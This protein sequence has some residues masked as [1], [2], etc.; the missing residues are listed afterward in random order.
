LEDFMTDNDQSTTTEEPRP[1]FDLSLT[2]EGIAVNR[3][4]SEAMASDIIAI[5]MGG[6]PALGRGVGT[7]PPRR[8][9]SGQTSI[10][11]YLDEAEATKI[12]QIITVIGQFLMDRGQ[13][14]F[15]RQDVKSMFPKAGEPTPSNFARDFALAAASIWIAEDQK[16]EFY[17]TDRGRGAIEAKFADQKIRRRSR[18][19]PK[20][21]AAK[22]AKES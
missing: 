9:A 2:G 6:V 5:V 22:K 17:V 10:R 11:E 21:N 8:S 4:I 14:R 12:P 20:R 13:D 19:P 16:N 1:K 18:R 3:T 15:T 7:A